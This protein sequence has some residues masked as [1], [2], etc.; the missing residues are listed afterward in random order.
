MSL[1]WMNNVKQFRRQI[2]EQLCGCFHWL[3]AWKQP[4]EV[5]QGESGWSCGTKSQPIRTGLRIHPCCRWRHQNERPATSPPAGDAGPSLASSSFTFSTCSGSTG[6]YGL[7]D[8]HWNHVL[9]FPCPPPPT[10]FFCCFK[11]TFE[12]LTDSTTTLNLSWYR[13]YFV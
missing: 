7:L 3:C 5:R 13:A 1:R 11:T 9:S 6:I 10:F 2:F 4:Q 12:V 8:L